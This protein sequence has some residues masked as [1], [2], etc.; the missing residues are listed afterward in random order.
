[1]EALGWPRP[2]A[3]R[4]STGKCLDQR[5]PS[6]VGREFF[7]HGEGDRGGLMPKYIHSARRTSRG[8]PGLCV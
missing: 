7:H 8:D 3:K 4:R 2:S 1:M 5:K 6:S